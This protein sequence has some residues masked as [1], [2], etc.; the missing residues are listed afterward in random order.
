ME[1]VIETFRA[2]GEPSGSQVRAR[3]LPGQGLSTELR[4]ECAK[5]IRHDFPAGSLFR[6]RAKLTDRE[7]GTPFVYTNYRDRY[8]RLTPAQAKQFIQSQYG[9]RS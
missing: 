2:Q 3:P 9:S 8:E 1:I 6:V 7:G 5:R 4:V